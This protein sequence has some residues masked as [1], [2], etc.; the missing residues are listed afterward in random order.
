MTSPDIG[1]FEYLLDRNEVSDMN[2]KAAKFKIVQTLIE[3]SHPGVIFSK[4]IYNKLVE[5]FRQGVCYSQRKTEVTY[6]G[7]T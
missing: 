5:H 7:A 2:C 6:E 4:D 3:L 1:L